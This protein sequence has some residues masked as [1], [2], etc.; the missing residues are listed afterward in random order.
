MSSVVGHG[1][2]AVAAYG[3]VARPARL[4]RG[5]R[6]VVCGLALG[7][8]PDLD[9]LA[10]IA[11]PGVFSH[12]GA[13]HSVAF[14]LGAALVAAMVTCWGRWRDLPRAWLGL[15]LVALVHPVLDY[16]MACG[17]PVPFFW[18]LEPTGYLSPVQIVPTAYY[19]HSLAGLLA[20]L[21]HGPTMRGLAL[22]TLM[23]GPLVALGWGWPRLRGSPARLVLAA[24]LL[25]ASLLGFW[26]TWELYN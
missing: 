19:S 24:L 10:L 25:A 3:F 13:S 15:G 22:E 6:G 8:A 9:V 26:W 14:A 16:L 1:L 23:F 17:P 11:L 2:A 4:L 12:R 21:H 7:V 18:P 5:W 20:L